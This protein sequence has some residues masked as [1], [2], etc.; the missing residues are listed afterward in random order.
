[1]KD[2][3]EDMDEIVE[4]IRKLGGL[5]GP[6]PENAKPIPETGGPILHMFRP[7]TYA[8]IRDPKEKEDFNRILRM[9]KER[10]LWGDDDG[11]YGPQGTLSYTT[12]G[13]LDDSDP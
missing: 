13:C 11:P 7:T 4:G 6:L 9:M 10:G 1:M 12:D 3:R 2:K 5:G 8:E